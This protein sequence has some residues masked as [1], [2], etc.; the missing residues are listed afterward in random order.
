M[1]ETG[2]KRYCK[3]F[4]LSYKIS[5]S[6]DFNWASRTERQMGKMKP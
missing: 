4:P 5:E 6:L 3:S 1:E 2:I